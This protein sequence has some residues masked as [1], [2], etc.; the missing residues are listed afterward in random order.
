MCCA[1]LWPQLWVYSMICGNTLTNI[2]YYQYCIH[3]RLVFL[4][5]MYPPVNISIAKDSIMLHVFS[6]RALEQMEAHVHPGIHSFFLTHILFKTI[7]PKSYGLVRDV[8]V[9]KI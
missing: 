4:I 6:L 9:K 8:C 3:Y 7:N 1:V 2:V 5:C